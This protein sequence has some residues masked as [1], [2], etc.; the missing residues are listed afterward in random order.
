MQ[1]LQVKPQPQQAGL[2]PMCSAEGQE[3]KYKFEKQHQVNN[4]H[5]EKLQ[6]TKLSKKTV[7][8]TQQLAAARDD[9]D[10]VVE[11][12]QYDFQLVRLGFHLLDREW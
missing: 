3:E 10:F 4:I 12:S 9:E 5:S 8:Q 1:E 7:G 6:Y 11:A 2:D